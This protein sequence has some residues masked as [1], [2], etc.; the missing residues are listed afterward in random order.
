MK[1][2]GIK[3]FSA[4][5]LSILI[6]GLVP[7]TAYA[8]SPYDI[9]IG[10][11]YTLE[12]G[13]TLNDD[14]FIMGGNA[15]LMD[16]SVVNGTIIL[17]GGNLNAAGQVNGDL[18]VLGGTVNLGSTFTMTGDLISAGATVNRDPGAQ[19]NGE[20]LSGENV[21]LLVLPGGMRITNPIGNFNPVLKIGGF[22]LR[23]FVWTL[24]A[25]VIA[26]FIPTHLERTS[27]TA[28][29]QPL[30]AGGLGLI[31]MIIAPMVL[32]LL[33]ITICLIPVALIGVLILVVAWAFGMV[34]LGL[35]VGK[36]VGVM[37]KQE[38]HP[39]ISA[40]LGTLLLMIVLSGLEAIIPCIGWIPKALV[41]FIGLGAVLLTQFGR[42]TTPT[43]P[44]LPE[45]NPTGAL[46]A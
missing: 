35:E 2:L 30:I 29:S 4:I 33:A 44:S 7:I 25:M 10:N 40:G 13:R 15:T 22:F 39:A 36:R 42:K 31:T 37:F 45:E 21:P 26:M 28:L 18:V 24:I 12:S 5:L 17:L 11:S 1:T 20:I 34:A 32:I 3:I 38:W 23:L 6:L 43:T 9:V 46:P 14:L 19:I 8:A 41:G 16:G 27:Q